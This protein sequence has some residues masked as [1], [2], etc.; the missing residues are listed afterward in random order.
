MH[1]DAVGSTELGGEKNICT[2][3]KGRRRCMGSRVS[4][5]AKWRS[6]GLSAITEVLPSWRQGDGEEEQILG[7]LVSPGTS[8]PARYPMFPHERVNYKH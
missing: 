3:D 6:P 1:A 8:N 2:G 4:K 7:G 5:A